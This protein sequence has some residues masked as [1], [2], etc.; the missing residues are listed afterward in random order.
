M[1]SILLMGDE[2][3]ENYSQEISHV[4]NLENSVTTISWPMGLMTIKIKFQ[5]L[6]N[7][8]NCIKSYEEVIIEIQ[9][10]NYLGAIISVLL[11]KESIKNNRFD[12]E[13][14][15]ISLFMIELLQPATRIIK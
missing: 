12:E 11:S 9:T 6:Q 4:I 15:K 2:L 7:L 5:S 14:V 3:S 1:A 13:F 10:G 8:T